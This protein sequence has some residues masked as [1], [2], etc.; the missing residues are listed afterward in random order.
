[1][2]SL[3]CRLVAYCPQH[4]CAAAVSRSLPFDVVVVIL[5]LTGRAVHPIGAVDDRG[6]P[7]PERH[8]LGEIERPPG[9]RHEVGNCCWGGW[10]LGFVFQP[11][12]E[13]WEVWEVPCC[14]QLRRCP[15]TPYWLLSCV[16]PHVRR[17]YRRFIV[18]NPHH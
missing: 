2:L 8:G 10:T 17:T 4:R 9:L 6:V 3:G 16:V 14:K 11:Q 1:M 15:I 13:V 7:A 18:Q 5:V 12:H